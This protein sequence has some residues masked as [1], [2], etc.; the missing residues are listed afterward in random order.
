EGM[1]RRCRSAFA[2]FRCGDGRLENLPRREEEEESDDEMDDGK[3]GDEVSDPADDVVED[4]EEAEV[5]ANR[6]H[7]GANG[8]LRRP[9]WRADSS[10]ALG[11]RAGERERGHSAA[12]RRRSGLSGSRGG[13]ECPRSLFV[14]PLRWMALVD[15]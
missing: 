9:R 7:D 8:I 2:G 12:E 6:V 15:L 14:A 13:Q 5:F 3:Q 1:D 11:R 4:R 10:C